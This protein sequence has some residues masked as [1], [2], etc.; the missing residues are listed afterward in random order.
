MR[1][2]IYAILLTMLAQPVCAEDYYSCE[3][4]RGFVNQWI[5]NGDQWSDMSFA[6]FNRGDHQEQKRLK[7]KAQNAV[8]MAARWAEIYSALCKD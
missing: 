6:A 5:K 7:A 3:E 4:I 1:T 2:L 8:S